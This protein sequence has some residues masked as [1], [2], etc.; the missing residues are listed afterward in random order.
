MATPSCNPW[1]TNTIRQSDQIVACREVTPKAGQ[2]ALEQATFNALMLDF[3]QR[4][5]VKGVAGFANLSGAVKCDIDANARNAYVQVNAVSLP[6]QTNTDEQ[7]ALLLWAAGN[8]LC[9]LGA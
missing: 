6:I 9:V 8:A 2:Y 4:L 3:F 5:A 1:A 7:Q